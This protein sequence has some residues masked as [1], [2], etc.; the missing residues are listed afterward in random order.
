[1]PTTLHI[2]EQADAATGARANAGQTVSMVVSF[3]AVEDFETGPA[4]GTYDL[5]VLNG[6]V[7]F[8]TDLMA[9]WSDD[10]VEEGEPEVVT[11]AT[12]NSPV[13]PSNSRASRT[14]RH[15]QR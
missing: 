7:R 13:A 5:A 14:G 8:G 1:M 12:W 6:S 9:N 3:T 11:D 2:N 4:L 10:V 15:S